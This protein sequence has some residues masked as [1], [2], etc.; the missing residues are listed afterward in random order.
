MIQH[1]FLGAWVPVNDAPY[2]YYTRA[3]PRDIYILGM[4]AAQELRVAPQPSQR[5]NSQLYVGPKIQHVLEEVAPG[6]ELTVD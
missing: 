4:K 6:L 1:Y 5:V 3:L 2:T